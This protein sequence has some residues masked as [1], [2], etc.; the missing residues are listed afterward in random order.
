VHKVVVVRDFQAKFG[1]ELKSFKAMIIL[2]CVLETLL[3]GS[4]ELS[5]VAAVCFD[6]NKKV[7]FMLDHPKK[8]I[9]LNY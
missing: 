3:L 9:E 8:L 7:F 1:V 4:G 2:G 6:A 5:L